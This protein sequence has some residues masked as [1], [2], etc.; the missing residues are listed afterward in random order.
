MDGSFTVTYK[1]W[2]VLISF[3]IGIEEISM[4]A[5]FYKKHYGY[6]II[7][8]LIGQKYNSLCLTCK[9]DANK[10]REELGIVDGK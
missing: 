5:K 8:G 9:H 4:L 1:K 2:G 3:P 6:D 10:W 7:D